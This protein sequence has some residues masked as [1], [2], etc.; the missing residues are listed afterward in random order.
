MDT[1]LGGPGTTACTWEGWKKHQKDGR[2]V[3]KSMHPGVFLNRRYRVKTVVENNTLKTQQYPN[4]QLS[5]LS[6]SSFSQ[7]L[8]PYMP[9]AVHHLFLKHVFVSTCLIQY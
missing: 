2:L 5:L 9:N 8:P 7:Q 3:R 1:V 4:S 6:C